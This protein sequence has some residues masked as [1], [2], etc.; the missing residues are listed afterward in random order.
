[1]MSSL[2]PSEKYSC[3]GSPLMLTKGSTAMAGRSGNGR[4]G[5]D[6]SWHLGLWFEAHW[7]YMHV[8]DEAQALA[9][10]GAD[11]SLF[12][13]AVAHRLAGSVD[14]A[15]QGRIGNDPAAPDRRNEIVL[16]D[17]TVAVLHQINQQVEHLRLD[18]N[19]FVA[20][21]QLATA[22]VKRMIAK[23]KLHVGA[24]N[25]TE[26]LV[27]GNNQARLKNKSSSGQSLPGVSAVLTSQSCWKLDRRL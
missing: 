1:M 4:A 19:R 2:M 5:R 3:S 20:A 25:C 15:G 12:P 22:V 13:T 18:G 11:Q 10:D 27:S 21:A 8:A 23:E 16:A 6:S 24:P 9:R 7:P 26:S 17:D 14:T